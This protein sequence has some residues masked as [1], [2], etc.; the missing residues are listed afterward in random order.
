M[1]SQNEISFASGDLASVTDNDVVANNGAETIDLSAQL[2]LDDFSFL[3][4]C[5]GLLGIR[6]EGRVGSDVGAR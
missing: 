3:Q 1:C 2:D 6:L 5:C 4:C